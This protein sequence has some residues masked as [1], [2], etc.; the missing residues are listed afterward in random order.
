VALFEIR[1][2]QPEQ[3]AEQAVSHLKCQGTLRIGQQAGA[4]Q[5]PHRVGG[6]SAK[7][8]FI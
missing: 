5:G 3:M 7:N 4:D 2:W 1:H 6:S 8:F